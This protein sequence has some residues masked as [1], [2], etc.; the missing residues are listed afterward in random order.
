MRSIRNFRFAEVAV[1]VMLV[2]PCVRATPIVGQIDTFTGSTDGWTNGAAA[3][4]P[5]V[6][7]TGGPG[8]SGDSFLELTG[9]GSGSGGRITI[10]NRVQWAG[11]FLL[12]GVNA[13]DMDLKNL[14]SSILFIRVGLKSTTAMGAPGFVSR[15]PFTL[16]ADGAWH[17][18]MFLLEE[19][20]VTVIGAPRAFNNLL[21]NVAEFR[22][23]HAAAPRLNGDPIASQLGIDNIRA[24]S[25]P[26]AV[27]PEPSAA[28][29]CA[30]GMG[31]LCY[32]K[33]FSRFQ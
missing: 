24:D 2:C 15:T 18:A 31:F 32:L 20:D 30:F 4:D 12:A 29:I 23:L 10:F 17:H 6:V 9:D 11:N 22:I 8:G 25:V 1:G 16:P 14:G 28:A 5:L 27:V 13:V 19:A 7:S 3:P 33:R 26:A 21:A